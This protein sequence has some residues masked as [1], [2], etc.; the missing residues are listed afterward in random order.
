[1]ACYLT[2]TEASQGSLFFHWSE[3]PVEG[4]LAK[5]TPTKPPPAFKIKDTGGRQE[6][7]RGLVGPGSNKFY[8]GYCQYLK[9]AA[10]GGGSFAIS[11][12]AEGPGLEVSVY[13]LDSGDNIVRCAHGQEYSLAGAKAVA[14]T[15]AASDHL[16]GPKKMVQQS[17]LESG[18][19]AGYALV[20]TPS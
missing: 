7:I 11:G 17:F 3:K 15:A 16:N 9:A 10:A 20:L 1:M 19:K 5:H 12:A 6:I 14:V 13:I 18:R 4:A 8:E 2:F